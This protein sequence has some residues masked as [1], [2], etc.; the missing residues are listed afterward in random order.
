M[1]FFL[2]ID[3]PPEEIP[4]LVI[5]RRARVVKAVHAMIEASR[6]VLSDNFGAVQQCSR[7]TSCADDIHPFTSKCVNDNCAV[8]NENNLV[9]ALFMT[10]NVRTNKYLSEIYGCIESLN[11][12]GQ[13]HEHEFKLWDGQPRLNEECGEKRKWQK[14]GEFA[15]Q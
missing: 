2:F 7:L 6:P 4:F 3:R 12:R 9:A 1:R 11:S 15:R 5:P 8:V 14:K 10:V 13:S